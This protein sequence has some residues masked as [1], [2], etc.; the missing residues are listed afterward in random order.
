VAGPEHLE[1]LNQGVEIWIRW[2]EKN[3]EVIP[4]L[5]KVGLREG[6]FDCINFSKSDLSHVTLSFVNAAAAKFEVADLSF[7][8]RNKSDLQ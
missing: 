3:P 8:I 6:S 4:E 5:S 1:I 7:A 2:R